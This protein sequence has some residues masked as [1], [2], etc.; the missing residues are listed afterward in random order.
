MLMQDMHYYGLWK[1]ALRQLFKDSEIND[2]ELIDLHK[3]NFFLKDEL[4]YREREILVKAIKSLEQVDSIS[5]LLSIEA[6]FISMGTF[7]SKTEF[8]PHLIGYLAECM[9]EECINELDLYEIMNEFDYSFDVYTEKETYYIDMI[10]NMVRLTLLSKNPSA[11][12]L[13]ENP[14]FELLMFVNGMEQ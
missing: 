5:E 8:K 6:N 4:S 14:S 2:F 12:E 9:H 13:I 3:E 1:I 7:P 10:L 11:I